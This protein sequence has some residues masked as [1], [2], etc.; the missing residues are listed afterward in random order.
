MMRPDGTAL[1]PRR[2]GAIFLDRD[3]TLTEPRHYPTRPTDLILQPDIGPPLQALQQAGFALVVATNQS[4]IARGLFDEPAL[5]A[6]NSHLRHL[7]AQFGVV[8]DGIYACPHHPDGIVVQYQG[9]CDCRKPTPGMLTAAA[10][11]L[12]LDLDKS[13]MIGDSPCDIEA[14]L[15][16]GTRTALLGRHTSDNATPNVVGSSTAGI[17]RDI[18]ALATTSCGR[19]NRQGAAGTSGSWNRSRNS[20][21][22]EPEDSLRDSDEPTGAPISGKKEWLP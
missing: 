3:G 17:L 21:R 11:D 15:R 5:E 14:G 8:L 10:L 1:P 20:W 16:A 2:R 19:P 6:M 18:L 9:N 13:W 22:P 7:L 4:G 12:A